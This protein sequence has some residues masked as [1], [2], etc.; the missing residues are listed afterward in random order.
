MAFLDRFAPPEIGRGGPLRRRGKR[1]ESLRDIRFQGS[2]IQFLEQFAPRL[3]GRAPG[4]C[5][6]PMPVSA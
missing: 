3:T 4:S 6:M 1:P 5:S 2:D